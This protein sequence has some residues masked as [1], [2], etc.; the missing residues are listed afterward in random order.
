MTR[1]LAR[2]RSPPLLNVSEAPTRA[3]VAPL[4]LDAPGWLRNPE[5]GGSREV[6]RGPRR[7]LAVGASGR[8]P[9]PAPLD[10]Q[11]IWEM[12]I[13]RRKTVS[14]Q[15]AGFC[16]HW[17]QRTVVRRNQRSYKLNGLTD[18]KRWFGM[19]V[20]LWTFV[21]RC[22]AEATKS[23]RPGFGDPPGRRKEEQEFPG[24]QTLLLG[25]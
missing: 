15:P 3:A 14:C 9:G 2:I 23:R 12:P 10:G 21:C 20:Q 22:N 4:H 24:S 5:P 11:P 13:C 18:T 6:G 16:S 17:L 19:W 1:P 25:G 7:R 8:R